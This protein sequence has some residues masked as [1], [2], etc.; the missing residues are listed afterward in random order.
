MFEICR[1]LNFKKRLYH[2]CTCFF[3]FLHPCNKYL[4]PSDI[5]CSS[6]FL[7]QFQ[8]AT[9]VEQ[10]GYPLKNCISLDNHHVIPYNPHLL[11][12][13]QTHINMEWHNHSTPVNY[14]FKYINKEYKNIII[15]TEP[16]QDGGQ[17]S[18]GNIDEI[19]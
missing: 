13:Y 15:V 3:F 12:N 11:M 17:H 14:L 9:D 1:Q 19:K 18:S 4:S 2:M 6:Y 8:Q 16:T 5:K 7:K 10:D